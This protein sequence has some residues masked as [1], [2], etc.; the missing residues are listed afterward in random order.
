D[1]ALLNY[2]MAARAAQQLGAYERRD[3]YLRL[4]HE[5]TPSAD[6]A[7]GITQAELQLAHK[8]YGQ[9]LATLN[10]L[11]QISPKHGYV[12]KLQARVYQQLGD[13]DNLHQLLHEIKKH[14]YLS[15]DKLETIEL[16]TYSGLLTHAIKMNLTDKVSTVWQQVPKKLK[17]SPQLL[18][19]YVQYLLDHHRDDDAEVLIRNYL[20]DHWNDVMVAQY[21]RLNTSN[22]LN[23]IETAE[24]WLLGHNRSVVLLTAL[25]KLCIKQSLWGKARSYLETSL[26]VKPSA[27][28][29]LLLAKLLDDKMDE[30]DKAQSLYQKGL[31]VAVNQQPFDDLPVSVMTETTKG[32]TPSLKIIQ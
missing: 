11:H 19:I 3:E 21:S 18:T 1:T 29:Y 27:E 22:P 12:K 7:I 23:Q 24:T 15:D 32:Q 20:D 8:Q 4:A 26:D 30:K 31:E 9:A 25:G 28:A 2:L 10:Y 13:W 17:H 14:H 16:E 5:S 6:I